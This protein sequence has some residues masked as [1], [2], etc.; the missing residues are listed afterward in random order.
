[1]A[2]QREIIGLVGATM[3]SCNSVLNVMEKFA[4]LLWK[5]A[6]FATFS[7]PFTDEPS[8]CSIHRY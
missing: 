3:L 1:M 8:R 5:M 7:S 4:V 6:I 2:C